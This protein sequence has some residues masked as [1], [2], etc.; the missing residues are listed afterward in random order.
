[1]DIWIVLENADH[2]VHIHMTS[3]LTRKGA[4]IEAWTCLLQS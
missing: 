3:H 1:M 2:G 4:F